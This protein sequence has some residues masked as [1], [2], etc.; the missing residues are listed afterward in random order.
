EEVGKHL[1][2]SD[3]PGKHTGGIIAKNLGTLPPAQEQH[4]VDKLA[5][6]RHQNQ[7]NAGINHP[8]DHLGWE[9][10]QHMDH[11]RRLRR[12]GGLE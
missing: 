9:L 12:R 6:Q 7:V 10:S 8:A 11:N 4:V 5:H 3:G 2:E 1:M